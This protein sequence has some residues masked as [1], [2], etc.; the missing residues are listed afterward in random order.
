MTR[1][2]SAILLAMVLLQGPAARAASLDKATCDRLKGEQGELEKA[3]ARG[4]MAKG[5][6]WAKNNLEADKLERIRRL[7]EVDEQIVFR[8]GGR[9]LVELP[10]EVEADPAAI[11]AAAKDDA[12][13]PAEAKA[14]E[15]KAPAEK[16]KAA[17]VKA[18]SKAPAAKA[19]TPAPAKTAPKADQVAAPK[20]A[21]KPKPKPK[22]KANDAYTPPPSEPG[23][24]PFANQAPGGKN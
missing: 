15:K 21:A 20:D 9:P 10:K 6:E 19:A 14:A 18:E 22:L 12:K 1:L 16:K 5:P 4:S 8:C 2:G 24:N 13:P 23:A 7:I 11:P 17:A 3:G